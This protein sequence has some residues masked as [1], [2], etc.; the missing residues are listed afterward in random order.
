LGLT[1]ALGRFVGTPPELPG[2]RSWASAGPAARRQISNA[3]QQTAPR[4]HAI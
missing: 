3:A 2:A 4:T 1:G